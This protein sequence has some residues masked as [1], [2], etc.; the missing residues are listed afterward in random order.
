MLRPPSPL[1]SRAKPSGADSC[2]RGETPGAVESKPPKFL[3]DETALAGIR[4][5]ITVE[6]GHLLANQAAAAA[7]DI[8][9]VHQMR[10]GIRRL[11]TALALWRHNSS[12]VDC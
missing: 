5:I 12:D 7:R 1:A 9:G 3:P 2:G 8:E 11:R 4:R 10:V 6:L